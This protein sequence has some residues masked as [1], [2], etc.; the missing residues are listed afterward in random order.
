MARNLFPPLYLGGA[1]PKRSYNNDVCCID[2]RVSKVANRTHEYAPQYWVFL[3][4]F[5]TRMIPRDE[6]HKLVPHDYSYMLKKFKRP[7]QRSLM[8]RFLHLMYLDSPWI[9]RAFQKAEFYAKIAAPRNI[10]TLPVDHN[11]RLGQFSYEFTEQVLKTKEWYAFSKSPQEIEQRILDLCSNYG[12]VVPTDI[13]KC[14]GSRGYIH[15]CLDV[16]LMMRAFGREYHP[17]ILRLLKKEAYAKG[18]TG[19]DFKYSCDYNT[20]SGSSKTSWGNTVTNAFNTFCALRTTMDAD[21][22][23]K[24]L[25]LFGGDDGLSVGVDAKVL[26]TVTAKLG[27]LLKSESLVSGDPVPFLG[28]IYLDPWTT[29]ESIIDVKRQMNHFHATVSPKH[30]PDNVILWRK[31]EGYDVNDAMTPII[32]EYCR[33]I[34][35]TVDPPTQV[36]RDRYYDATKHEVNWWARGGSRFTPLQNQELAMKV[37]ANSL[38]ISVTELSELRAKMDQ[39]DSVQ[40]MSTL[41]FGSEP[42]VE[43]DAVID[44][45]LK[46]GAASDHQAQVTS[47]ASQPL[48][49]KKK[50]NKRSKKEVKVESVTMDKVMITPDEDKKLKDKISVKTCKFFSEGKPCPF[51]NCKFLH[52]K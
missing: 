40:K 41:T 13:S 24:S 52:A 34:Y 31:A 9:V 12:E 39:L 14:D 11:I 48:K 5:L 26:S 16:G 23:W 27:M 7:T 2:N 50:T 18:V 21:N 49:K 37:V 30:V 28:R 25:G 6:I 19:C 47:L 15:Y 42:K 29:P 22:A 38:E 8:E 36:E 32:S 17:E 45:V 3:D 51:K 46:C 43:V 10:S 1:S 35:R 4:E 33:L 44:G 20:L